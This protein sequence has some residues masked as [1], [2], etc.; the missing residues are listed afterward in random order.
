M[1]REAS[2]KPSYSPRPLAP[3]C[4]SDFLNSLSY[5]VIDTNSTGDWNPTYV[6]ES[7]SSDSDTSCPGKRVGM[8]P[9]MPIDHLTNEYWDGK[10]ARHA[11]HDIESLIWILP[12]GMTQFA[13]GECINN[14]LGGWRTRTGEWHKC[15]HLKRNYLHSPEDWNFHP[16]WESH[17]PVAGHLLEWLYEEDYQRTR[18][19]M[20]ASRSARSVSRAEGDTNS[21]AA[22][23][24]LEVTDD[25]VVAGFWKQIELIAAEH[26]RLAYLR[27][28]VP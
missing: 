15:C 21:S 12:W 26:P 13:G 25:V 6:E 23:P 18:S 2:R 20:A 24:D 28:Y 19:R 14:N 11:R 3:S 16:E 8:V 10:R 22:D 9:F 27:E 1:S 4:I 7:T 17:A 5:P